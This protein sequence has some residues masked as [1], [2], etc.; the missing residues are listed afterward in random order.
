MLRS[1]RRGCDR[2]VDGPRSSLCA[3]CRVICSRCGDRISDSQLARR[4]PS[5]HGRAPGQCRE[6]LRK[7][8]VTGD[9]RH[10]LEPLY[11]FVHGLRDC[12]VCSGPLAGDST[13]E[14]VPSMALVRDRGPFGPMVVVR[15]H[16]ACNRGLIER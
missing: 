16:A 9:Y 11:T 15:S 12:H 5:A 14:H 6:C 1:C 13:L 8:H 3:D 10:R 4:K 7:R 2:E